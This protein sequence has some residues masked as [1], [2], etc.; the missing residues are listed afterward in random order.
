MSGEGRRH[1]AGKV[2]LPHGLALGAV[3]GHTAGARRAACPNTTAAAGQAEQSQRLLGSPSSHSLH[4]PPAP[5][6]RVTPGLGALSTMRRPSSRLISADLPAGRRGREGGYGRFWAMHVW[7]VHVAC[8]TLRSVPTHSS[9]TQPTQ[10]T[11]PT[12]HDMAWHGGSPLTDVWEADDD[13]PH[14]PRPQAAR[15]PLL[16]ELAPHCRCLLHDLQHRAWGD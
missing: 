6:C 14:R 9:S 1:I 16:I 12:F 8:H 13:C 2:L 11:T 5:T 10:L 4:V 7:C 15:Q 3:Q